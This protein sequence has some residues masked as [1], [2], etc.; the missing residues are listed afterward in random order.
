MRPRHDG[1]VGDAFETPRNATDTRRPVAAFCVI[2][3]TAVVAAILTRNWEFVFHAL[4]ATAVAGVVMW[5]RRTIELSPKLLWAMA[6][7]AALHMAGGLVPVPAGWP[8]LGGPILYNLWI[9]DGW[10]KYDHLVHAFGFGVAAVGFWQVLL[11]IL[12]NLRPSPAP[13]LICWIAAQG[14]GALNEIAEFAAVR[15]FEKTNVGDFENAMLDLLSNAVGAGAAIVA[16]AL[17][18]WRRRLRSQPSRVATQR[19][20]GQ[21]SAA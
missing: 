14:C 5:T 3:V 8:T 2:V 19:W 6:L 1:G 4:A 9:V 11:A 12:P 15:M 18:A 17:V 20:S 10:L 7:C 21:T 13:L 16:I